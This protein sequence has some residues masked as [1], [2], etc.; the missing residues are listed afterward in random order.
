MIAA[1]RERTYYGGDGLQYQF[2]QDGS[3]HVIG[4]GDKTVAAFAP[5]RW[6][7]AGV[8][9]VE[10]VAQ[11]DS[12]PMFVGA[13]GGEQV[14]VPTKRG[15]VIAEFRADGLATGWS[16]T[17]H[18]DGTWRYQDGHEASSYYTERRL[19]DILNREVS[20]YTYKVVFAGAGSRFEH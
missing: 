15:A 10:D 20:G 2:G 5:G 1:S 9:Q 12:S 4:E 18:G 7:V 13:S 3:L 17:L 16:L 11:P 8:E 14:E 6:D 19:L